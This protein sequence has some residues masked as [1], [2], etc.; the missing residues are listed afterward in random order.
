MIRA[1]KEKGWL[2]ALVLLV[3]AVP[4]RA[5]QD[6]KIFTRNPLDE[7]RDELIRVLD[8]AGVPFTAEQQKSITFVL[9]E[10]RRASEQLFGNVMNFS[11]GPPQGEQMDRALAGIQWM[12]ED[13][14]KRIRDYLTPE[15][16]TVWD[17]YVQSRAAAAEASKDTAGTSQQVQQIRVNNNPFTAENQFQGYPF[18][19]GSYGYSS[20]R[21]IQAEIIN[22][23]GTGAWHGNFQFQLKDESLDARNPFASNKPSYQQRNIN[24]NV[25]GPVLRNRLTVG[26]HFNQ[27]MQD[28][29]ATV[30]AVTP[31]GPVQ[32]GFTRPQVNR[33][34]YTDGIY[35]LTE[36]QSL[37]FEY[38]RQR[39]SVGKQGMG[40]FSLPERAIDFMGGD[41][42]ISLRHVWFP[43]EKLVQD[44]SFSIESYYQRSVPATE[45]RSINVL[46]AFNG[47]SAQNRARSDNTDLS[48]RSLWIYTAKRWTLRTGGRFQRS[49]EDEWS[50]NN[51]QG[52]FTFSSLD[53]YREG[54]PILYS[55]IRGDP[56]LR[57]SQNEWSAF[58]QNEYKVTPRITLFFGLRYEYQS[59]LDDYNNLDP[60]L[61]AAFALDKTTVL[62]AGIGIFRMR[63][64]RYA[65]MTLARMDGKRQVEIVI[66]NPSYPNPYQSGEVTIVPPSSRRVRAEDLV[67]PY[68]VNT[69][70]Q[71]ERSFPRNLFVTASYDYHKAF[72]LLRSRNLNAPLPGETERPNPSEGNVW[73]LESTGISKFKAFRVSMS[74]RFSIFNL[75]ASYSYEVNGDVITTFGAPT[76]NFNLRADYAEYTQHQMNASVNSRLF[77]GIY[78]NTNV[79]ISSGDPYTITTGYDDNGD[80]VTNDRP[81]GVLR[82]SMRGPHQSNVSFNLSKAFSLGKKKANAASPNINLF[83][84][85]NNAFNRTNL[86]TPVGILSSP[87]FGQSISAYSPRQITIGMRFQF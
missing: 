56:A 76:D 61:S 57:Y 15:Q 81:A 35:Q 12:N 75:N 41:D 28:N 11:S 65:E 46:G 39:F 62:R 5:Q 60:R 30:N 79:S 22:R 51:F 63:I 55:E 34:G 86:G 24:L 59:N 20:G 45:G 72:H 8:E 32:I 17:K 84:N 78:L 4:A 74:Q 53:S 19:G 16:R 23:G 1:L 42:Y 69:S 14:S 44:I 3:A 6:S 40:G 18:S 68:S 83:A 2:I 50:E 67:A 71:I 37:H 31:Q 85:M 36:K 29:A 13:F 77:F 7:I 73:R 9:E 52:T 33:Y 80:G 70:F 43:S 49:S 64:P 58:F 27:S 10:S 66:N 47:G 26:G 38:Y 87:F 21:G 48:V 25:S 54:L 82:Y